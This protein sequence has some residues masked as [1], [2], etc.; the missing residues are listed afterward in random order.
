MVKKSRNG[1]CVESSDSDYS[2]NQNI[3][4]DYDEKLS[5]KNDCELQFLDN[6]NKKYVEY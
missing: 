4:K 2:E 5:N 6:I 1:R 3:W